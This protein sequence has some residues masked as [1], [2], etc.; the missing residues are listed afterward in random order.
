MSDTSSCPICDKEFPNQDIEV[1]VNKCIFL[2][3]YDET[4]E[5]GPNKSK[6]NFGVFQRSPAD[7]KKAKLDSAA[8]KSSAKK[9]HR[10]SSSFVSNKII[11]LDADNDSVESLSDDEQP[12]QPVGNTT[13]TCI[14]W[15]SDIRTHLASV[16]FAQC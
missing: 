12:K 11:N 6:R 15:L 3:T 8:G 13:I 14:L 16:D 7:I 10:N 2:N 1:H 9:S 4:R 5:S